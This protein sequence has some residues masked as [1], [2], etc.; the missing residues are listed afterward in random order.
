MVEAG[1]GSADWPALKALVTGEIDAGEGSG[2][3]AKSA[4]SKSQVEQSNGKQDNDRIKD[5]PASSPAGDGEGAGFAPPN[6]F[7]TKSAIDP[8]GDGEREGTY[9]GYLPLSKGAIWYCPKSKVPIKRNSE[10]A[11]GAC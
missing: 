7:L 6:R 4:K 1:V 11:E 10:R 3:P 2:A 9:T 5:V 8:Q